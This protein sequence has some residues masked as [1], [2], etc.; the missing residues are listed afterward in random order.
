V[1]RL[2]IVL[3]L[4]AFAGC[5][6]ALAQAVTVG[7][8]SGPV[9][10][11]IGQHFTFATMVANPRSSPISGLVAHLNVLSNDPGTYVDPEDWS[12][13]RTQYLPTIGPNGKLR[14]SWTVQAVNSGSFSVYVAVLPRHGPGTVVTSPPLRVSVAQRRTLN[15]SG[16]LPLTL[17]IPVAIGLLGLGARRR[18][19]G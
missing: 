13:H 6:A 7:L 17:G 5:M 3:A 9:K 19:R 8:Q 14:L 18:R 15:S 10:T 16:V 1:R 12:S 4:L 11:K 2:A